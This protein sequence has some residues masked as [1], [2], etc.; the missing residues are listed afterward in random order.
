MSGRD[1]GAS[2]RQRLLNKSRIPDE[3]QPSPLGI[4]RSHGTANAR[5]RSTSTEEIVRKPCATVRINGKPGMNAQEIAV[6]VRKALL[7]STTS[8][9]SA[10]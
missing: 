4:G 6:S 7:R 2:V 1:I 5:T 8:G 9:H 10:L 3:S